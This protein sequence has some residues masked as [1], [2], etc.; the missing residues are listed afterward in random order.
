M[1]KRI[2]QCLQSIKRLGLDG[3]VVSSPVNIRYLSGS[4]AVEGYFLLTDQALVF[5]TN[6]IY[7]Q[8]ARKVSFWKVKVA[9]DNIFKET[10]RQA[11]KLGI[12]CLGFEA[13]N[14]TWLEQ[15]TLKNELASHH[16]CLEKTT[17]LIEDLRAVKSGPEL[18]AIKKATAI[19]EEALSFARQLI[20]EQ[21]SEQ[22]LVLEIEKFMKIKGDPE[23]AFPTIV[24]YG[25]QASVPHHRP[26]RDI[27]GRKNLVL[28]D[29]GAKYQ[30]YCADLTRVFF[31]GKMPAYLKKIY[32]CVRKA[33]DEA[34][35]K[36]KEG[37]QAGE[38]DRAARTVIE[39]AGYG[40]FFGHGLG[41]GV[42]LLVHEKPYLQSRNEQVLRENMV[43][44]VEP[45]IYLPGKGGVRLEH[46][47]LVKK[48]KGEIIDAN[49]DR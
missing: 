46:M 42:G 1:K 34:L 22:Q 31:L 47:V 13:K 23:T 27:L 49:C 17:D 45:A 12:S 10:A 38:V 25:P 40:K 9:P 21:R 8:E 3:L 28:I 29:L 26:T 35:K 20:D 19:T 7:E 5:I 15:E 18:K 2:D 44:T 39:K 41:H 36:I 30:G 14:L 32:D 16:I 11:K 6:F 4:C 37:I 33:Q 48:N 43:I 24:A